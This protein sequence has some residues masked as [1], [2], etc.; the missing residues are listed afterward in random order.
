MWPNADITSIL[1]SFSSR[2]TFR[3]IDLYRTSSHLE[4]TNTKLFWKGAPMSYSLTNLLVYTLVLVLL[5]FVAVLIYV[6]TV[7]LSLLHPRF[8]QIFIL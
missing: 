1:C 3:R 6:G 8:R 4:K 5:G 7:R 2:K